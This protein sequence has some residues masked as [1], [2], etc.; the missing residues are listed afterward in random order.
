M[1]WLYVA[2]KGVF[3]GIAQGFLA[4]FGM[5][6][7]QKLGRAEVTVD[8]DA[9]ALQEVKKAD[10]IENLNARISDDALRLQLARF[11]RPE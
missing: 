6:D 11:K 10:E 8:E 1:T 3:A 2:I 7:A 4:F 9:K 5:S